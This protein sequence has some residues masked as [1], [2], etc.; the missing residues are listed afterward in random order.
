MTLKAKLLLISRQRGALFQGS[1][2]VLQ[3]RQCSEAAEVKTLLVV[4]LLQRAAEGMRP[5]TLLVIPET[6][7]RDVLKNVVALGKKN[8]FCTL[9]IY[10][11]MQ[12]KLSMFGPEEDDR[13][14]DL[15]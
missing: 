5:S 7:Q 10:K 6:C 11:T 13:H 15:D 1:R 12:P 8:M 3:H 2:A 9:P 4:V 14:G